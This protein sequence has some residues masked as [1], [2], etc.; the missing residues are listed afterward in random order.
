[1]GV[2]PEGGTS[3]CSRRNASPFSSHHFCHAVCRFETRAPVKRSSAPRMAARSDAISF[4]DADNTRASS[5][6]PSLK[7]MFG[8]AVRGGNLAGAEALG[9]VVA[10]RSKEKGITKVVFDR[11][12]NLYHGRIRAVADGARKAGL[13]F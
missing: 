2:S 1:M 7:A 13:E 9:K 4:V 11:G 6:E 3:S 12:G 5:T 10:E 8:G